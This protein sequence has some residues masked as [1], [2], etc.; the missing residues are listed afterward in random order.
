MQFLTSLIG[1]SGNM[2]LNAAMALGIVVIL[3]I[4]GLWTLKLVFRASTGVV[5]GR[6]RR[7]AVI[8]SMQVDAKRQLIIIR[9][10][11]VEHLILTG[12][13]QDLV[14]E[15]GFASDLPQAQP[16][17][18]QPLRRPAATPLPRTA[19]VVPRANAT[20]PVP[21]PANDEPV[22]SG[23]FDR[24]R[25]HPANGAARPG[26]EMRTV[27]RAEPAFAPATGDNSRQPRPD[28]AT[29]GRVAPN[30]GAHGGN[31]HA[32]GRDGNPNGQRG[33]Y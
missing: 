20:D 32:F 6:N 26:A 23:V 5:R 29:T 27:I 10:D 9:R 17:P 24:S 4:L 19:P 8:D 3:I 15:T 33:G 11:E 28:S 13:P 7:L 16:R 25:P 1:G 2:Y 31:G 14:I 30:G 21:A 22:P 12:G 18:G